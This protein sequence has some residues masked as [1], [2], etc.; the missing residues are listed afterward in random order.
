MKS[1]ILDKQANTNDT[2]ASQQ[3]SYFDL[4]NANRAWKLFKIT[5]IFRRLQWQ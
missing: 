2:Y 1:S 3:T 4:I 5:I